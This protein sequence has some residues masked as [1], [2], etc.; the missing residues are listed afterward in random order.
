MEDNDQQLL[1]HCICQ[2]EN[3]KY[4][5]VAEDLNTLLK[6]YP[7]NS[8]VFIE[9]VKMC[10]LVGKFER[11]YPFYLKLS[12]LNN[13]RIYGEPGYLL[14]LQIG[15]QNQPL[16]GFDELNFEKSAKWCQSFIKTGKEVAV[17]FKIEDISVICRDGT[18]NYIF[19]GACGSCNHLSRVRLYR[20]FLVRREF[21][22]PVCFANQLFEYEA[23]K[24]FL[25]KNYKKMLNKQVYSLDE[26]LRKIQYELNVDTIKGN[27][28]S[29]I[30]KYL[31]QDYIFILNQFLTS[32]LIEQK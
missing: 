31:N 16:P 17:D 15:L 21:L 10:I 1:D 4:I 19:S 12:R 32:R 18:A 29:K 24:E 14:R 7:Q 13:V 28:Y 20:T 30:S 8:S 6:K 27:T 9:I 3:G 26:K 2:R 25:Q 5:D 23:I 22:C 11:A